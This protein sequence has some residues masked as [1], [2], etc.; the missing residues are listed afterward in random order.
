MN[1]KLANILYV[2]FMI[3]V[4]IAIVFI[5]LYLRD[6]TGQCLQNPYVYG[7]R[8]M[9]NVQCNC[10]QFDY[11]NPLVP[12]A[13]FFFN[14]TTFIVNEGLQTRSLLDPSKINFSK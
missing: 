8:A 7:A 13:T 3:I 12:P 6:K 10:M 11:N 4:L 2:G 14:D 5:L 1:S 9:K